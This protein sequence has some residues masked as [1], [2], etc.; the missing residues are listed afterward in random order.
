LI[1]YVTCGAIKIYQRD[2]SR[3]PAAWVEGESMKKGD[4]TRKQTIEMVGL[5]L[6]EKVENLNCDFTGRLQTDG[7][8]TVEFAASVD[9]IGEDG[10][11]RILTAYYYQNQ[12]KLYEEFGNLDWK[13]NGY[14]IKDLKSGKL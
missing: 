10:N 14:E 7:D 3:G 12:E 13:A 1:I 9:F 8:D 4:L 5:E 6:V 11:A 2:E